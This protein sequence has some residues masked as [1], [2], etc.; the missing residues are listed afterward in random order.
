MSKRK[1]KRKKRSR[2]R[3][4]SRKSKKMTIILNQTPR[5]NITLKKRLN[6]SINK[7]SNFA[8]SFSPSINRRILQMKTEYK[9]KKN[10]FSCQKDYIAIKNKCVHF[11]TSEAQKIMLNNLLS[12]DTINEKKITAPK[13]LLANCWFNV[14]FMCFFISDKGRKFFRYLRQT[15][16]TGKDDKNKQVIDNWARSVFFRLNLFIEASLQGDNLG[17]LMNTNEIIHELATL[18]KRDFPDIDEEWNPIDFYESLI[19]YLKNDPQHILYIDADTLNQFPHKENAKRIKKYTQKYNRLPNIIVIFLDDIASRK[20]SS[21]PL[22]FTVPSR[23][24]HDVKYELDSAIIRDTKQAHFASCMMCNKKEYGFDGESFSRINPIKWK[25]K[26]FNVDK[27]WKFKS[28][29][30]TVFNFRNGMQYLFYY[31]V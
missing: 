12:K 22:S 1:T 6:F 2:S 25:K 13:Q 3:S 31:R 27:E 16:I 9:K 30:S 21:K 20:I 5:K 7:R 18:L 11:K 8:R 23:S 28:P 4:I 10:I 14:F 24:K 15:M 19:G 29:Y 17:K 26:L